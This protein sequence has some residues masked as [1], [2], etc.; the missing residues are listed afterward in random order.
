MV[1]GTYITGCYHYDFSCIENRNRKLFVMLKKKNIYT[2]LPVQT[3][4]AMKYVV[5][6]SSCGGD[7]ERTGG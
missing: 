2:G 1:C 7:S 5:L 6:R 3:T 4:L